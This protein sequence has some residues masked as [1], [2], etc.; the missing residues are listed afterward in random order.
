MTPAVHLDSHPLTKLLK[1]RYQVVF[2]E[3][4]SVR[5]IYQPGAHPASWPMASLTGF[6]PDVPRHLLRAY[7]LLKWTTFED[8][9]DSSDLDNAL[10]IINDALINHF[11]EMGLKHERAGQ[12]G[13]KLQKKEAHA[14]YA[15]ILAVF[16]RV[17]S[18]P[19][20]K[21]MKIKVSETVTEANCLERQ[22]Y[23]ALEWRKKETA[24][25]GTD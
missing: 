1:K 14:R 11:A 20:A 6:P 9:P 22:V 24:V 19:H 2:D 17:A 25:S 12:K 10:K 3:I 18:K 15:E 21:T 16:D 23:R 7:A 8:P 13:V 5:I 4:S